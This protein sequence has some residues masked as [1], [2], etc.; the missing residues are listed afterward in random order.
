LKQVYR[1]TNIYTMLKNMKI[2]SILSYLKDLSVVMVGIFLTLMLTNQLD[3]Y[4]K[5]KDIKESLALIKLEL[6]NNI[7]ELKGL[8][9]DF[10]QD[11][12]MYLFFQEN[13][14]RFQTASAD[15]LSLYMRRTGQLPGFLVQKDAFEVFK[16]SAL[17]P[18]LRDKAF[19]VDMIQVYSIMEGFSRVLKH[20]SDKKALNL[21]PEMNMELAAKRMNA[22]K[23][24]D[25]YT[26]FSIFFMYE[27]P[28]A[29]MFEGNYFFQPG[30][31]RWVRENVENVVKRIEEELIR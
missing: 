24:N 5:Q 20:Y 10:T 9:K 7:E 16:S 21:I 15:T 17:M 8:E 2:R 22:L 14:E 13:M 3:H 25:P 30:R 6:E 29:F 28:K 23:E 26:F 31:I 18:Y 11:M 12:E 4:S 19:L 1:K 27:Q